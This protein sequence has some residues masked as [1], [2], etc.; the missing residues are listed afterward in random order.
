VIVGLTPEARDDLVAIWLWISRDDE[1]TADAFVGEL[2]RARASLAPD[3][4]GSRWP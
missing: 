4:C 1:K 3:R 2:E